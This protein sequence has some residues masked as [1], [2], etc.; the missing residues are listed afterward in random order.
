M[1]VTI[2]FKLEAES[3]GE[4]IDHFA[5]TARDFKDTIED[6]TRRMGGFAGIPESHLKFRWLLIGGQWNPVA[7][8]D[9]LLPPAPEEPIAAH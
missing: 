9:V 2:T 1:R 3:R 8:A 7:P 6:A 4:L 5:A